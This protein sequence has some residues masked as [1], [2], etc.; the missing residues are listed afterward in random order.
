[1]V[2]EDGTLNSPKTVESVKSLHNLVLE[3]QGVQYGYKSA[4]DS[5]KVMH[6]FIE[7]Y[8]TSSQQWRTKVMEDSKTILNQAKLNFSDL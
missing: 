8:N 3:N 6:S 4:K 5:L 7:M 1:M 2:F